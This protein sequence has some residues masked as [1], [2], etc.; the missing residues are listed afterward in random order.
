MRSR[1]VAGHRARAGGAGWEAQI[2]AWNDAYWRDRR[3]YVQH[4][5]PPV[6]GKPG[7]LYRSGDGPPDYVGT[8]AGGRCVVF[9]AK[10]A[11]GTRWPFNKLTERQ[12]GH[13]DRYAE[14]GAI[15][16]LLLRVDGVAWWLPW[17]AIRARWHGWNSARLI[18]KIRG[19]RAAP[20]SASLGVDDLDELGARVPRSGW[21]ELVEPL[22]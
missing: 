18:H 5:E 22:E 17:A 16:G 21:L 12:A 6:K 13:L 3:A 7:E 1:R 19:E 8:L 2:Q 4:A 10:Q 15:V 20:G 14:L 11:K 9:E